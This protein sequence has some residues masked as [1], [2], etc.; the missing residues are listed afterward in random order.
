MNPRS[1]MNPEYARDDQN[2]QEV[3][4]ILERE[5]LTHQ[6]LRAT[7]LPEVLAATRALEAWISAHP[8]DAGM[9]DA[10]EQ[11]AMMQEI[12][13]DRERVRPAEQAA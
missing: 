7:T 9:S 5:R 1:A 8:E 6:V 10:F 4:I 13:E 2:D 12:A 3:S 11:L